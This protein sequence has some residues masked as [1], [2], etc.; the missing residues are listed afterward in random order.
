MAGRL[1]DERPTIADI[2]CY[3]Y[4]ALIPAGGLELASYPAI[5]QWITRIQPLPGY[6]PMPGL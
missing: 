2:A 5:Q 1:V 3:P 4:T 6:Q